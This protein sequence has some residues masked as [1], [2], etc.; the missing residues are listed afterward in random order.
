MCMELEMRR[1][2]VT[3]IENILLK[4]LG[5]ANGITMCMELKWRRRAVTFIEN[6]LL[7]SLLEELMEYAICIGHR[8]GGHGGQAGG[9]GLFTFMVNFLL[10]IRL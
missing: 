7:N 8:E 4:S 9:G 5:R 2:A 6:I 1:R 3:F 10:S